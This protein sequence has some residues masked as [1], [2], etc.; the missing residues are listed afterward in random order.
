MEVLINI[1]DKEPTKSGF[2]EDAA[3][4]GCYRAIL[5]S[6]LLG[7]GDSTMTVI[8]SETGQVAAPGKM[9]ATSI[10]GAVRAVAQ[11]G[12]TAAGPLGGHAPQD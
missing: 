4:A 11:S 8:A 2:F 10:I 1:P 5:P 3:R 12:R 7:V 9:G 6:K